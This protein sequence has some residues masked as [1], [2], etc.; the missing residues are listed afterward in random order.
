MTT[1]VVE[2]C[3]GLILHKVVVVKDDVV[4]ADTTS[5][6]E[7]VEHVPLILEINAVLS[8]FNLCCRILLAVV[9]VSKGYSLRSGSVEEVV[10]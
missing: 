7:V 1:T 3:D 10:E 4:E 8:E 5:K 9:T 6:L 2:C